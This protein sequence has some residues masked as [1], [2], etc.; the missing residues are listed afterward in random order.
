[1]YI[2]DK[3]SG[4]IYDVVIHGSF[5]DYVGVDQFTVFHFSNSIKKIG[6]NVTTLPLYLLNILLRKFNSSDSFD[7]QLSVGFCTELHRTQA[8]LWLVSRD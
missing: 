5:I 1:M 6:H 7:Q 8:G 4:N 2:K 3:I